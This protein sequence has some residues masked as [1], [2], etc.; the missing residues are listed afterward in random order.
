MRCPQCDHSLWNQPV[1]PDGSP[2]IC[3]ECG[4]PWTAA[5]FDFGRGR[6]RFGCPKC[7]TPYYGTSTKGHLE[8][9]EFDCIGCGLHLSM[10]RCVIRAHDMAH[11]HDAMQRRDLPWLEEERLGWFR[12]WWRT[13]KLSLFGSPKLMPLLSRPP[14]PLRAAAFMAINVA[15]FVIAFAGITGGFGLPL[16]GRRWMGGFA[17]LDPKL[18]MIAAGACA[19][20]IVGTVVLA[21]VPALLCG[22]MARKNEP[23][24][25]GRAYEVVAYSSGSLLVGLIP[26][27]G[28]FIGPL[29]WLVQVGQ[30][31]PAMFEG[32]PFWKRAVAALLALGGFVVGLVGLSAVISMI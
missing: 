11:E 17:S 7:D 19:L 6:V 31:A 23:V 3:S 24:G 32:E 29:W 16:G 14:R 30:C 10:D 13:A 26:C 22:L 2:R 20:V 28:A 1:P 27:C 4:T 5:Q 15:I 8:P 9:A 18:W 12:R 25:F 21:A